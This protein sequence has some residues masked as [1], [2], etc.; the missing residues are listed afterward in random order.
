MSGGR[1]ADS[2]HDDDKASWGLGSRM[3]SAFYD[4]FNPRHEAAKRAQSSAATLGDH[5]HEGVHALDWFGHKAAAERQRLSEAEIEQQRAANRAKAAARAKQI[6]AVQAVKAE[7]AKV[8]YNQGL[9]KTFKK[10][11]IRLERPTWIT[12]SKRPDCPSRSSRRYPPNTRG[13]TPSRTTLRT[14]AVT[15]RP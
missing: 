3:A 12:S 10:K 6:Q 14:W 9:I 2:A 13:E 4:A 1:T 8:V 7:K 15:G 5:G 11:N